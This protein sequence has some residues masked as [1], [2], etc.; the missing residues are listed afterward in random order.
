MSTQRV[1]LGPRKRTILRALMV[2]TIATLAVFPASAEAVLLDF[3][4]PSGLRA[5]PS[6]AT[7]DCPN[8]QPLFANAAALTF[9]DCYREDGMTVRSN[10]VPPD[11]RLGGRRFTHYHLGYED[12]AITFEFFDGRLQPGRKTPGFVPLA[13]PAVEPRA[14]DVHE[15][16]AVVQLT[17]DPNRDGVLDR[18][19]LLS[20]DV[21]S[22]KL[23]VGIREPTNAISVYNNLH[24]PFRWTLRDA[25]PITRATLEFKFPGRAVVDNLAFE[26]VSS[27]AAARA[28]ASSSNGAHREADAAHRLH[29][30]SI[31]VNEHRPTG[32]G[33]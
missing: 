22:G 25:P 8:G 29:K 18:F 27:S 31:V 21:Y 3:N 2:A 19:R 1:V 17:Y 30:R 7:A 26:P 9:A 33:H 32:H 13:D 28:R 23:D 5:I 6:S 12:T 15:D 4:D 24:G 20:L 10:V 14:L 16:Q 11:P